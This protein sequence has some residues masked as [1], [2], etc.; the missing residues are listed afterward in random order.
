MPL[1]QR[2]YAQCAKSGQHQYV[3]A[4]QAEYQANGVRK[5]REQDH[6]R[7]LIPGRWNQ[8]DRKGLRPQHKQPKHDAHCQQCKRNTPTG[9]Y[10]ILFGY[11][12]RHVV[13]GF[14]TG[15]HHRL[16]AA[17][18]TVYWIDVDYCITSGVV[19]NLG[20]EAGAGPLSFRQ[21]PN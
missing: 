19:I 21:Q 20:V 16:N 5:D 7:K 15:E 4:V 12:G 18:F 6:M 14:V 8:I 1:V 13:R 3:P 9:F 11:T 2:P 10:V 17:M